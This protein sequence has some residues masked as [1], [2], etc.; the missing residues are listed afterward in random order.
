L[1]TRQYNLVIGGLT[2][3]IAA[4]L[5]VLVTFNRDDFLL[6][7]S[8]YDEEI[9]TRD[10][11]DY[12]DGV[13]LVRLARED[14]DAAGIELIKL[15]V[16][17]HQVE[18]QL[19]GE[20][21][22]IS[23]LL[24]IKERLITFLN[25]DRA[26]AIEEA[27]LAESYKRA[28]LLFEDRQN[29]SRRELMESEYQLDAVRMHRLNLRRNLASLRH[30]A[31]AIWGSEV[32]DWLLNDDSSDF[33]SL[34]TRK[35]SLVRLFV[36]DAALSAAGT[37]TVDIAPVGFPT[38]KISARYVSEA[39]SA[40]FGTGAADKFFMVDEQIPTGTRVVVSLSKNL[41]EV[42]GVF[43]PGEAVL[44]HAGKPWVFKRLSDGVF[45]RLKIEA[46]VDLGMGW[47]EVNAFVPGDQIVVS[48]AQL[49]LSEEL[50]YQIRN[51]NED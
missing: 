4:L 21:L 48:G 27:H 19:F 44:W 14:Q 22:D 38:Q 51:E 29:I 37:G 28:N 2:L 39:P 3:F 15:E 5:F 13:S 41:E 30:S 34:V 17:H 6:S 45:A 18:Y 10:L 16:M 11:T 25:E 50:K 33:K 26:K 1:N 47:F 12:E 43:I 9:E 8:D 24:E 36:R 20:I 31:S 40:Q 46:D 32:I 7:E 23:G 35:A 42:S 49:L